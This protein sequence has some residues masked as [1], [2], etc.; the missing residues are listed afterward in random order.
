MIFLSLRKI[1]KK[2]EQKTGLA[3][4]LILHTA[5]I[6]RPHTTH[7]HPA[8][9]FVTPCYQCIAR[10]PFH[11][12]HT[13]SLTKCPPWKCSSFSSANHGA[14]PLMTFSTASC[15]SPTMDVRAYSMSS[16]HNGRASSSP[17]Q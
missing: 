8:K 1:E 4:F 10:L 16:F 14:L 6:G 3:Q 2:N 12:P 15:S 9:M 13:C 11:C 7:R 5:V 17:I